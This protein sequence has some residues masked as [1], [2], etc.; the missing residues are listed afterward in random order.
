MSYSVCDLLQIFKVLKFK[1]GFLRPL[2]SLNKL[3][4]KCFGS[5]RSKYLQRV[6]HWKAT[7]TINS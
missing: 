5:P 2:A 6:C 1:S 7:T 3:I 4:E